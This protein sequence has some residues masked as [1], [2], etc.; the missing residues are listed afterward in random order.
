MDPQKAQYAQATDA[1]TLADA[2][3]GADI[4]LGLSAPNVLKPE[5]AARMADKPLIF[6]L[7]NPTPEIMPEVALE[8]RPD[9]I[10]ATGRSDYPNQVNNVLCFPYIF[11][12]ALDVRAKAITDEMKLACAHALADLARAEPSDI[13]ARA[14]GGDELRFGPDYLIPRPFDPRLIVE[15]APAVAKAAMDSGVARKPIADLEGYRER[16]SSFVFRSGTL[17]KPV[18]DRAKQLGRRIVYA[19]G[20]SRR[21]LRATQIIVDEGLAQPILIGRRAAIEARITN[22]GLRIVPDRDFV[23]VDP[24]DNPDFDR[25]WHTYYDVMARRGVN[26]EAARR[27][28]HTRNTA[29]AAVMVRCG[30]ADG[31]ICGPLGDFRM[32]LH[33]VLDV[34]GKSPGI[35]DV[36]ALRALILAQGTYFVCDT[37]VTPDPTSDEIAEMTMLASRTVAQFGIVPKVALL[38]H[39]DFGSIDA[40]SARKMAE[41]R[42]KLVEMAPDLECEGEMHAD[43]ALNEE[44]RERMFPRSRL[45][46][47]ANLLIMPNVEAA[48]ISFNMVKQLGNAIPIGPILLGVARPVHIV[49]ESVTVR[50]L[51]NMGAIAAVDTA[52]SDQGA[53]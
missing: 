14:Y 33:H 44:I 51:V 10:V 50:G 36:S 18:F 37:H 46:G 21:V 26:P 42:E 15:L 53:R 12:G 5:A 23:V 49:T 28:M 47:Q 40:P 38:S 16:L 6:A 32:H 25:H 11:R 52:R 27:L 41:A 9:A 48:N 3:D 7:A 4:F 30:D 34:V 2:I 1:R 17:M 45:T 22:L 8:V 13:V 29:L 31:A 35:G 24:N 19:E 39:S 43:T 20:E